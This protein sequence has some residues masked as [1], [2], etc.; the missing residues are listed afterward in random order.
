MNTPI[1]DN[2]YVTCPICHRNARPKP[3]KTYIGLF[4]CP[5]CQERL[6]VCRSGHYV[7][8]PFTF[9]QMILASSLRRQSSPFARIIRD[10]LPLKR[11]LLTLALGGAVLLSAI[12]IAQQSTNHDDLVA[13][14]N[15]R[16]QD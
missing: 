3:I 14:K 2:H 11:P 10:F 12:A 16:I 6:V 5:Y 8:D 1:F 15:E 9:K 4:T 7:R 13:P